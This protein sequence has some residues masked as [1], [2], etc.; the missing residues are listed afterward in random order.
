LLLTTLLQHALSDR[1]QRLTRTSG[2]AAASIAEYARDVASFLAWLEEDGFTG[3]AA[4]L[5]TQDVRDL[6]ANCLPFYTVAAMSG[7]LVDLRAEGYPIDAEVAATLSPYRRAHYIRRRPLL[8][9]CYVAQV[10]RG[11]RVLGA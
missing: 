6:L 7:A 8:L 3:T 9:N 10:S 2:L 4:E 1:Q 11:Q 5:T